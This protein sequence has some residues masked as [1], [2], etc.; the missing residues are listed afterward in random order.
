MSITYE[1]IFNGDSQGVYSDL[2]DA[3]AS[4]TYFSDMLAYFFRCE[5]ASSSLTYNKIH[6][7]EVELIEWHDG[8]GD[9]LDFSDYTP[10]DYQ[11]DKF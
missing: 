11:R 6:T 1:V 3:R 2:N 5:V 7:F 8:W 9:T 10:E 4:F